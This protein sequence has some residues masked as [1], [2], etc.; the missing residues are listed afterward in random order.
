ML[1]EWLALT[2]SRVMPM[3]WRRLALSPLAI[4]ISRAETSSPFD[5]VILCRSELVEIAAALA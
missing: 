3:F 1:I 4:T 5:N 2:I